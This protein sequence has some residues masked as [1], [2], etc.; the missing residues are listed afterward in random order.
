MSFS[1]GNWLRH[2]FK[3][4][5]G[6]I[7]QHPTYEKGDSWKLKIVEIVGNLEFRKSLVPGAIDLAKFCISTAL[8]S[9]LCPQ[10]PAT[11]SLW[12]PC[13]MHSFL[14]RETICYLYQY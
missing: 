5:E 9:S 8:S 10:A 12:K 3:Q 4:F 2:F 6:D 11:I 1:D 14:C 13:R 7:T